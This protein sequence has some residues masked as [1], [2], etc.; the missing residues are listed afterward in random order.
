MFIDWGVCVE[1]YISDLMC[2]LVIGK[3]NSKLNK[4]Y[5]VVLEV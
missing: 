5:N 2:V 3:I 4:V 1:G